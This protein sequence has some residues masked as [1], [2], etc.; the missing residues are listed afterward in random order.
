VPLFV[1][2]NQEM[3]CQACGIQWREFWLLGKLNSQ[4]SSESGSCYLGDRPG[5]IRDPSDT[6]LRK[7]TCKGMKTNIRLLISLLLL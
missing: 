3:C 1:S 2:N 6:T 4:L 7:V 5:G